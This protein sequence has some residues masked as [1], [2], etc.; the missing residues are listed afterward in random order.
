MNGPQLTWVKSSHT[1]T[2]ISL[3]HKWYKILSINQSLYI[4]YENVI[5]FT[6]AL[7]ISFF[8][9]RWLLDFS[10]NRYNQYESFILVFIHMYNSVNLLKQLHIFYVISN[11]IQSLISTTPIITQSVVSG[12]I[13]SLIR[14]V[15]KLSQINLNLILS[16]Y[17]I[18]LHLPWMLFVRITW[19]ITVLRIFFTSTKVID[20]CK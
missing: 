18:S 15:I 19:M 5:S 2:H 8:F 6:L 13:S 11:L 7:F 17:K 4:S 12:M 20:Y 10:Y 14:N 16:I 3:F 1:H 9:P